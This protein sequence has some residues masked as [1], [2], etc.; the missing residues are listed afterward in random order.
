MTGA[1]STPSSA[2]TRTRRT[3]DV[4]AHRAL[5]RCTRCRRSSRGSPP[6]STPA[7]CGCCTQRAPGSASTSRRS[8]HRAP[9]S[10]PRALRS[11]SGPARRTRA[12]RRYAERGTHPSSAPIDVQA[13]RCPRSTTARSPVA[14]APRAGRDPL[15][16]G[17]RT[18][19]DGRQGRAPQ[20]RHDPRSVAQTLVS[21]GPP[22]DDAEQEDQEGGEATRPPH[23]RFG[24]TLRA[25]SASATGLNG[26]RWLLVQGAGSELTSAW[27]PSTAASEEPGRP[28][29]S[30]EFRQ[31]LGV[32]GRSCRPRP[33]RGSFQGRRRAGAGRHSI[34]PARR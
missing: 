21:P 24:T 22:D 25:R 1:R 31:Q 8:A 18:Q 12:R 7:G 9:R 2:S 3:L 29:R 14:P 6:A 19:P 30:R 16:S 33:L 10:P 20:T 17:D 32:L 4:P 23:G 28:Y 34:P 26:R 15:D 13:R 27:R 11:Q 5:P